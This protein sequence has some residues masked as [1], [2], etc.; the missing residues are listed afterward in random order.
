MILF[1]AFVYILSAF[2]YF[3]TNKA[4]YSFLKY[5]WKR[6]NIN[7]YLSTEIFYLILT[8]LI[9]FSSNPFNWVVSILML[10]HLFGVAWLVASPNSF[11]QM[12]EESINLD[13]EM[14]ENMV[15]IMFLIYAA[16]ALFSRILI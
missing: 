15:V 16:M 12:A 3:Y 8:S 13:K 2:I 1:L 5:I 10:L 6:K 4:G 11:Y 9:V 7:V 14:V